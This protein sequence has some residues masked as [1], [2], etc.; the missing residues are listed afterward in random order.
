[1]ENKTE[2]ITLK[3]NSYTGMTVRTL[4]NIDINSVKWVDGYLNVSDL[5]K[6]KVFNVF[7]STDHNDYQY[8]IKPREKYKCYIFEQLFDFKK[9]CSDYDENKIIGVTYL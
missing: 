7:I 6:L 9:Q 8:L 1:M 2:P 4:E 3:V 5:G